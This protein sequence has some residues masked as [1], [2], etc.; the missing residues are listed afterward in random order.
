MHNTFSFFGLKPGHGLLGSTLLLYAGLASGA[1]S[2]AY[3]EDVFL[4]KVPIVLSASRLSQPVD[5]APAAVTVIDRRMI[6][7]SGAWNLA[8]VFRLVPGMYVAYHASSIYT[9]NSMVSYHGLGDAYANRM[10]VLV[11]GRSV[12][13]PLFGGVLWSDIPVALDDIERIEVVRGPD[14]ASYGAN[15]FLGIINIITLHSAEQQGTSL[16]MSAG[17]SRNEVMM[18]HGGKTDGLT[19]R[20]TAS[21]RNDRGEDPGIANPV[22][23]TNTWTSNKHDDKKIRMLTF[24]A[25]SQLNAAN[26]LEFQFGHNGGDREEGWDTD[27]FHP[28]WKSVD[29]HFELL[30]WRRHLDDG[31]EFSMQ[32][33]HG[34]ESAADTLYPAAPQYQGLQFNA[35]V[36]A[37]RYD[38][39]VQHAFSPSDRTRLVWGGSVRRDSTYWPLYLNRQDAFDFHLSRLFGNLEWRAQ[40][41]LLLN[42]GAM[43]ENNDFTGTDVTPRAAANWHFLPGHTLRAS[44]S[45]AARTPS[46]FEEKA[47]N[48]YRAPTGAPAPLPSQADLIYR[49]ATGGLKP[50]RI[51]ATEIGYLGKSPTLDLDFRLFHD[52]LTDLISS[53]N[54]NPCNP[55]GTLPTVAGY[56]IPPFVPAGLTQPGIACY[57]ARSYASQNTGSAVAKGFEAQI[58]WRLSERTR[59]I[60]GLAH[61][62]I[63]SPDENGVPYTNSAPTNSQSL[64]LTHRFDHGWSASLMGYQ[65]GE[66]HMI[67]ADSGANDNNYFVAS[68]RRWDGRLAYRFRSGAGN[69]ELA[70]MVQN[71]ANARYFEYRHDNEL[72][73]RTA[74]LNLKLDL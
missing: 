24:R 12:Y 57:G 17:R 58:Q 45:K 9:T 60:Y 42:L 59:L 44:Y 46:L 49:Y 56:V 39:E 26:V 36:V 37:Q 14:S 11:D 71:L 21:T 35:D 18:R 25:D 34:Y 70:L 55:A 47:D 69:G 20:L 7:E 51:T 1:E 27:S 74:W 16:S 6:R 32:L 61:T 40:P 73:G 30:R 52:E 22:D 67:G 31:G 65:A 64:M 28:R 10:Q 54:Y 41:D 8:E 33:Y 53:F 66:T 2:G 38:L 43:A 13:S 68:S 63:A 3:S 62:R 19:Y 15:S 4:D 50:E 5:E 29:N 23:P 72:P 48:R